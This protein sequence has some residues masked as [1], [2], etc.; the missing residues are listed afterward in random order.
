M[1]IPGW[2]LALTA[3]ASVVLAAGGIGLVAAAAAPP[4]STTDGVSAAGTPRP[5]GLTPSAP[6]RPNARERLQ[7]G[8]AAARR[9]Q[10]IGRHLVHVEATV[11]DKD[12]ALL[13]LWLDHGTVQSVGGG[14]VTIS[15]AGGGT[16]TIE[17]DGATIVRVGRAAGSLADLEAGAEVFVRSRVAD[18]SPVAK[19]ILV[20]PAQS[21]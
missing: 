17:T 16:R 10:R 4:R 7:M 5:S 14:S 12:G 15:E 18:G 1:R 21:G 11:T 3:V 19:R 2:R 20:V 6:T 9:L 13:V 8:P